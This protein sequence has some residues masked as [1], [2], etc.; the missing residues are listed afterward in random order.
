M[1]GQNILLERHNTSLQILLTHMRTRQLKANATGADVAVASMSRRLDAGMRVFVP[2]W[3]HHSIMLLGVSRIDDGPHET[4]D[5]MF[6]RWSK[7]NRKQLLLRERHEGM[8]TG[9][10]QPQNIRVQEE[11]SI[12]SNE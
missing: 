1:V 7:S 11:I 8:I 5:R 9:E 2:G 6:Q 12:P 10:V 4:S 3:G